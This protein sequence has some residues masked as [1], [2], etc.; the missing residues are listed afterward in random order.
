MLKATTKKIQT[1]SLVT[2][3]SDVSYPGQTRTVANDRIRRNTVLY[4]LPIHRPG[5]ILSSDFDKHQQISNKVPYKTSTN[6]CER[7]ESVCSIN[8]FYFKTQSNDISQIL[9]HSHHNDMLNFVL[10]FESVGV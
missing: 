5:Y 1:V 10:S 6:K 2:F 8:V 7:G 3:D 4:G 9:F